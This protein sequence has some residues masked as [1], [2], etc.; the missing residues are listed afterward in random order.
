M[1]SNFNKLIIKG[2]SGDYISQKKKQTI[3]NE[4]LKSTTTAD[5]NPIKKDGYTYNDNFKFIPATVDASKCLLF[6]K[7]Y[8]LR[9]EYKDGKQYVNIDCSDYVC[10]SDCPITEETPVDPIT[11]IVIYDGNGNTGGNPPVDGL[12]PYN[13]GSTVT[14]LGNTGTLVNSGYAF[15]GWNTQSVGNAVPGFTF[16]INGDTILYAVWLPL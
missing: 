12:S 13:P 2:D 16:T 14:I 10:S 1:S 7:S 9:T 3:F 4:F 8:E 11:Y 6:S 5:F 15:D